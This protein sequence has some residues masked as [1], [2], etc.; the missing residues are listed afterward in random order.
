MAYDSGF[1]TQLF[2]DG[3][4]QQSGNQTVAQQHN[5]V[6]NVAGCLTDATTIEV[7]SGSA[8][9][10]QTYVK[11]GSEILAITNI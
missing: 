7:D 4:S 2:I 9:T 8:L 6:N 10:T 11:I 5:T 3:K 1:M